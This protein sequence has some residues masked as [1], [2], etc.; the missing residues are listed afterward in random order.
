M[1]NPAKALR[2][3]KK[4][5]YNKIRLEMQPYEKQI[6]ATSPLCKFY[7]D[8]ESA[9]EVIKRIAS[10]KKRELG[11]SVDRLNK[12]GIKRNH[13][14]IVDA[15]TDI[16]TREKAMEYGIDDAIDVR[17]AALIE[18]R[19]QIAYLSNKDKYEFLTKLKELGLMSKTS[20]SIIAHFQYYKNNILHEPYGTELS[21]KCF[22]DMDYATL[23]D[24]IDEELNLMKDV[25]TEELSNHFVMEDRDQLLEKLLD[26]KPFEIYRGFI[27]DDDEFDE[28]GNLLKRTYVRQ[29][30]KVDGDKYWLQDAG[31]G[32]SYTLSYD[33]AL[34]FCYYSLTFD[35]GIDRGINDY[36]GSSRL[37]PDAIRTREESIDIQSRN[38]S[39][40]RDKLKKKPIVCK[41][42]IN[43]EEVLGINADMNEAELNLMPENLIVK[44]YKIHTS[45]EI[46]EGVYNHTLRFSGEIDEQT[47]P[48]KE[49]G[50]V[51]RKIYEQGREYYIYALAEDMNDKIASIRARIKNKEKFNYNE[52][53]DKAF[54]DAAI[55]IP[56]DINP[57]KATFKWFDWISRKPENILR[58]KDNKYLIA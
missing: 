45:D 55:A 32:V 17:N 2:K 58:K 8:E 44:S 23:L 15:L 39:L 26:G 52:Q 31:K 6:A 10:N 19:E 36:S 24:K 5:V 40:R 22:E 51:V 29:G 57:T 1:G 49:D 56:D 46:G 42:V 30:K 47:A 11:I 28:D 9:E 12:A 13:K 53:I 14:K 38:I 7:N 16:I 3:L 37:I 18:L 33:T 21:R 43:P 41:Y 35:K 27:I 54:K 20:Y 50:I 4:E 48:Y 34:F 25:D